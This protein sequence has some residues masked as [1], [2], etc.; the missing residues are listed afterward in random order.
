MLPACDHC[1]IDKLETCLAACSGTHF[2]L[3]PVSMVV[4][5]ENVFLRYIRVGKHE[6]LLGIGRI[7]RVVD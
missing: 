3:G 2:E 1:L 6:V 7:D 4:D 5:T